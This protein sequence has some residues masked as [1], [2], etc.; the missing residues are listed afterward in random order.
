MN[1]VGYM[2]YLFFFLF[3]EIKS[4]MK[5]S[6]ST[7]NVAYRSDHVTTP[8]YPTISLLELPLKPLYYRLVDSYTDKFRA[9]D[10]IFIILKF[11]FLSF[12]NCFIIVEVQLLICKI[13][14]DGIYRLYYSRIT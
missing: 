3:S 12:L 8:E 6:K 13:E 9:A 14:V 1:F 7:T 5:K 2:I 4:D 11:E 10:S